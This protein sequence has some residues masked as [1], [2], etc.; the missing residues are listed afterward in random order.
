MEATGDSEQLTGSESR[1]HSG[2]R[3]PFQDFQQAPATHWGEDAQPASSGATPPSGR[4]RSH[5]KINTGD[6]EQGSSVPDS[7]VGRRNSG[8]GPPHSLLQT[9][10]PERWARVK[11]SDAR[12]TG[13]P[14][15]VSPA[16]PAVPRPDKGRGRPDSPLGTAT[17]VGRARVRR[18]DARQPGMRK[19]VSPADPAVRRPDRGQGQPDSLL[20]T[21]TP[22]GRARVEHNDARHPGTRKRLPGASCRHSPRSLART[23]RSHTRVRRTGKADTGIIIT[24]LCPRERDTKSGTATVGPSLTGCIME[25]KLNRDLSTNRLESEQGRVG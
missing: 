9:A 6:G 19:R 13:W 23:T 24:G 1:S 2:R 15:R 21:A 18:N 11:R 22:M 7:N 3:R 20:G 14:K 25:Q 10:A 5:E 12:Q 4:S 16:D 8:R 17:P